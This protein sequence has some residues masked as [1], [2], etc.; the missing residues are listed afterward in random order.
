MRRQGGTLHLFRGR[1]YN[2]KL[3]PKLPVMLWK[4][5]SP[6]YPKLLEDA[7]GGLTLLQANQLRRIGRKIRPVVKLCE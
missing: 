4:P 7:P 1:N 5:P 6:I 3:R 2:Y